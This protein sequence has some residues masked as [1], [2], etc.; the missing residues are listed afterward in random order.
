MKFCTNCGGQI[1]CGCQERTASDGKKICSRCV[2]AYEQ[3]LSN[4][5]TAVFVHPNNNTS[6]NENPSS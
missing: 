5:V 1:T 2:T 6:S 4:Q 3:N